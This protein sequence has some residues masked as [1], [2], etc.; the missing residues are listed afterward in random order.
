[1]AGSVQKMMAK[2]IGIDITLCPLC[3]K[4][5]M[6]LVAELP[7]PSSKHFYHF[8]RAPNYHLQATG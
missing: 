5:T 3:K 4:G 7:R 6:H 1:M 2:L 8:I